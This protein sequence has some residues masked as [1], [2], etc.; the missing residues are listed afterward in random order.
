MNVKDIKQRY[1]WQAVKKLDDKENLEA[2]VNIVK[3]STM[4]EDMGKGLQM[5]G[6]DEIIGKDRKFKK[7]QYRDTKKDSARSFSEDETI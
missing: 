7:P 2:E 3:G 6:Q 5:K 4:E 1:S